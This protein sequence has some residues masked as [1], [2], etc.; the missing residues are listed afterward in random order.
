MKKHLKEKEEHLFG[1]YLEK[2][3]ISDIY[4]NSTFCY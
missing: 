1:E 4:L 3:N 2:M